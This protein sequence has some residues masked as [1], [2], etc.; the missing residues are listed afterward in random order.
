MQ[1]QAP[2]VYTKFETAET[3]CSIGFQR[4]VTMK[5]NCNFVYPCLHEEIVNS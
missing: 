3:Q 2:S 4:I 5:V 1:L